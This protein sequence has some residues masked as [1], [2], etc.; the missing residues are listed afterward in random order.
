MPCGW[1][2]ALAGTRADRALLALA[3]GA[4]A[5]AWV[6][7]DAN[8]GGGPAIAR[9][10]HGGVLLAEY[11]LAGNGQ[12]IHV[13]AD[14]DLG[15]SHIVIDSAGARFV[16]SPCQGKQ[17]VHAGASHEPGAVLACVPNRILISVESMGSGF[18]AM[19]G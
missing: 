19:A 7:I 6:A 13:D 15:P 10:Y 16:S 18:D 12:A 9:I 8:L 5:L 1:V 4:I 17:C 2:H 11:P 3:M 14:G